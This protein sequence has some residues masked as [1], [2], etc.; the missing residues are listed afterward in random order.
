MTLLLGSAWY[1]YGCG[2]DPHIQQNIL[3]LRFGHEKKSTTI[4]SLPLIQEGE[5]M[6]IKYW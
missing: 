1:A 4:L 5:R 6:G 3:S 2:F